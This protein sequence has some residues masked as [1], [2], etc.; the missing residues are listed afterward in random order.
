MCCEGPLFLYNVSECEGPLFL[1]N[2]CVR[3]GLF[4]LIAL[5]F[6]KTIVSCRLLARVCVRGH[7]LHRGLSC[8]R[9]ATGFI[10]S[11]LETHTGSRFWVLINRGSGD[12]NEGLVW[13][14]VYMF[15]GL[16]YPT[17]RVR[18]LGFRV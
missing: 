11:L 14:L 12:G 10:A 6:L 15:W 4:S 9:E 1:Y 5:T 18:G 16:G 17:A 13:G 2:V 3:E 8:V 7:W